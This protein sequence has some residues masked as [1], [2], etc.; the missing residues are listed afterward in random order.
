MRRGFACAIFLALPWLG[1][2]D[3]SA[4]APHF[5][6]VEYEASSWFDQSCSILVRTDFPAASLCAKQGRVRAR[7]IDASGELFCGATFPRQ[8]STVS[9]GCYLHDVGGC[10][11]PD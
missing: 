9:P 3:R 1:Y 5:W 4:E 8:Q 10:H 11:G 7:A 6:F 2:L